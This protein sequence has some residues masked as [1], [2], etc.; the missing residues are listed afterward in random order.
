MEVREAAINARGVQM[1]T[2]KIPVTWESWGILNI[3]ADSLQEALEKADVVGL[4]KNGEYIDDTF[5]VDYAGIPM[6]NENLSE[7]EIELVEEL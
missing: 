5:E 4:P 1:Q 7:A 3:E 2:Y 6:Y